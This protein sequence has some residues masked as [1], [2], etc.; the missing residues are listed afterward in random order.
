MLDSWKGKGLENLKCIYNVPGRVIAGK[1][2]IS[3]QCPYSV[4]ARKIGACPQ[5]GSFAF[6]GEWKV[7]GF[8]RV[9]VTSVTKSLGRLW[10]LNMYNLACAN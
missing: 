7:E 6:G 5:C 2:S 10:A 3:S 9:R 4:P 1:L 8:G